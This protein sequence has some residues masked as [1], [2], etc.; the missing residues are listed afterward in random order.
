[1][2]NCI[3]FLSV[4]MALLL[5][6]AAGSAELS[7]PG[8]LPLSDKTIHFTVGVAKSSVVEDWNTNAMTLK[9]Q[10]DLNVELEFVEYPSDSKEL[11]QKVELQIMA[12]GDE[13][14]DIIMHGLGGLANLVKYGQMGMIL[15]TT[16]YYRNLSYFVDET[17]ATEIIAKEDLLRFVTCYDGEIYGMFE[18][19]P[20]LN[21]CYSASRLMVYEPWLKA[22]NMEKPQT[23]DE[24]AEM[25]RRFK[26]EDPNGN[27][28]NDE[29]PMMGYAS[30]VKSNFMR[31]LMNPF[32][33][34]QEHYWFMN[35]GQIDFAATQEGWKEG[36]KWIRS[37]MTEGLISPLSLTQD[38]K[39]LTAVMTEE[40]EKVGVV[41]RI[42]ATNLGASD[43]RRSQYV[44]LDP[45]E[46][47]SGQRRAIY[48]PRVPSIRMVITKNCKNPEA[49]FRL[50]DY[51]CSEEM[52]VWNRY[53][54]KGVD[55]VEPAA[56]TPGVY[57]ALGYPAAITVISPWGVLQNQWWAAV[58]P[59][60]LLNKYNSGQAVENVEYN[61]AVAIGRSMDKAV[62]YGVT[63]INGL[64]YNE[65]EQEVVT[66]LQSTIED[67]VLQTFSEFITGVRDVDAEWDNYVKEFDKMGLADYMATVNS[68][69]A[70]M[71]GT[72]P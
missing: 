39:Q 38:A 5:A 8:V 21:N 30:T 28:I 10:K 61:G 15:P 13:L 45:L 25:L 40:P 62:E 47:P 66:E 24:F 9:L 43:I 19:N 65:Q 64:V 4:L 16:E 27:G 23:T 71:Y 18:Y 51:M 20:S 72:A 44:C 33:V 56:G 57:E 26:T 52:S 1:M 54:E 55:W 69:Y 58:G 42:S 17:L 67:Y 68:C 34:T 63:S 53:G 12:G 49:A 70:R 35:E 46:G 22:L 29:I 41:A 60:I 3:R 6:C 7:A 31:A 2:K 36:I 32:I 50:G 11:I 37:L 14:P 59:Q 48:D